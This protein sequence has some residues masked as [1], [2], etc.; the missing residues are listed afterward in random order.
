MWW[1]ISIFSLIL[2]TYGF[3]LFLIKTTSIRLN[4][5]EYKAYRH[6]YFSSPFLIVF[7]DEISILYSQ[8]F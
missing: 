6:Y 5:F 3:P 2:Q 4:F 1:L 8:P 7:S